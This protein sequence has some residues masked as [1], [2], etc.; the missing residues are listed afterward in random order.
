MFTPR[1]FSAQ[2]PARLSFALSYVADGEYPLG[3]IKPQVAAKYYLWDEARGGFAESDPPPGFKTLP[4]EDGP[5]RPTPGR[6][7]PRQADEPAPEV[8]PPAP[9]PPP[10]DAVGSQTAKFR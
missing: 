3:K 1:L 7:G 9:S 10:P 2:N 8:S 4:P 6:G 5:D